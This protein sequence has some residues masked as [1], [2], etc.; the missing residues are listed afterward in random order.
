M[1]LDTFLFTKNKKLFLK[2]ILNLFFLLF[3]VVFFFSNAVATLFCLIFCIYSIFFFYS[4]NL[5][6]I[7]DFLDKTL[8]IFF[9]SLIF[10]GLLNKELSLFNMI[11]EF[12]IIRFFLVYVLIK[13]ILNYNLIRIKLFFFISYICVFFLSLNILLIHI[14]GFDIFLNVEKFSDIPGSSRF[15]SIFGERYISGSYLLNFFFFSL[16]FFYYQKKNIFFYYLSMFFF[17]LAILLS[18]DRSPFFLLIFSIIIM[19]ILIKKKSFFFFS[20]IITFIFLL[21]ILIYPKAKYRYLI[22]LN[23]LNEIKNYGNQIFIKK[24]D[25]QIQISDSLEKYYKRNHYSHFSIFI[26]GINSIIYEKT[27]FGSGKSTFNKRCS[28]FKKN[29]DALSIVAGY[30]YACPNHS[31]NFYIEIGLS[32]G[33]VGLTIISFFLIIKVVNMIRILVNFK[34][35]NSYKF[36]YFILLFCCFFIEIFPFK[37]SGNIFNTYNGFLFFFKISFTYIFLKKEFKIK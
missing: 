18:F 19:N 28:N 30:A 27:L 12:G 34:N 31:H 3:P 25:E 13:N 15:P 26:D 6:I 5:K 7:F 37:P 8:L 20:L 23:I 33:I 29:F 21:I 4:F 9:L 22:T 24:N 2:N 36:F 14:L 1:N 11:Q 35:K 32:S 16:F 17:G 10:S